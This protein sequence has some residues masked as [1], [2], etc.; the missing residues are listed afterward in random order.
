MRIFVPKEIYPGEKR[1]PLVPGTAAKLVRLGA[2][3][4]IEKGLGLSI[5]CADTEYEGAGAR[6]ISDR[7]QSLAGADIV[8]RVRKP[9][10]DEIEL[11]KEGCIHVSLLDSFNEQELVRRLASAG[12]SAVSLEMIPRTA[13]AQKMDAL[14]SQA[15]LAGYISVILAAASINRIFPMMATAAGTIKPLRMFVIGVGV[16]GLQ[17]IATGRRL[18]AWVEAFDTR[19]VVEE[20]VKSLGARFVKADLG[21]TGETAGG[22]AKPLTPEQLQ[23]QREVIAKHAAQADAVIT[24]AQVFG[25][26]APVI[27]TSEIIR[28]M[29]PGSVI[30]DTAV[31][32][33]GNVECSTSEN[34][35]E[36]AGVKILRFANLP[37]QVAANA[38]EMYSSNLG[39]FVEHFWDKGAKQFSLDLTNDILKACVITHG[40]EICNETI[41]NAYMPKLQASPA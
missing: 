24:A 17:A 15:N 19:A 3:V 5:N 35:A 34:V 1:A 37:S 38:S 13:V 21:E 6:L 11:L 20:Q 25:R 14:S 28:Q 33:G 18:G 23:K 8:L 27:I 7:P 41:R 40:G 10:S 2:D 16:A 9:P 31:E 30:V 12:V 36:V 29:K 4:E 32:T 39:A 22:Y 26:K